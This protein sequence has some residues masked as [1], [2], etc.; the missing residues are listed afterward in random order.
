M[1]L[2]TAVNYS[3]YKCSAVILHRCSRVPTYQSLKIMEAENFPSS[4]S[5]RS[6]VEL[7]CSVSE[8]CSKNCI[9]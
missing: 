8:L 7:D 3:L 6:H 1:N 2:I 5:D 4:S 9:V